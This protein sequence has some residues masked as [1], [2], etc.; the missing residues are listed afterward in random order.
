MGK[1]LL[2]QSGLVGEDSSVMALWVLAGRTC[3]TAGW[4][5]WASALR[6]QNL[7]PLAWAGAVWKEQS[8]VQ[9]VPNVLCLGGQVFPRLT[10]LLLH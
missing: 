2:Q 4:E 6:P 8:C 10:V 1:E 3:E 7:G 9:A 5:V